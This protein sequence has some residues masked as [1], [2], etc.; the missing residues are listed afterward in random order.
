M[1]HRHGPRLAGVRAA[2][3]FGHGHATHVPLTIPA[4]AARSEK[5]ERSR[6]LLF[7]TT[8][9]TG[10][11]KSL[12]NLLASTADLGRMERPSSSS[13]GTLCEPPR[14]TF[15]CDALDEKQLTTSLPFKVQVRVLDEK[16]EAMS[17]FQGDIMLLAIS[18]RTCLAEGFE[19]IAAPAWCAVS[20]A[21]SA[22]A[23]IHWG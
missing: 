11:Q 6:L 19:P 9:G 7:G 17:S 1:R 13:Q 21:D 22:A 8:L 10:G 12:G 18:R 23:G 15:V 2:E 3:D 16:A 14:P 20:A 5:A 4:E